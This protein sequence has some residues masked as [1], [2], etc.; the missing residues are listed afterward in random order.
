MTH[1]AGL[2]VAAVHQ[3]RGLRVG[4]MAAP[5]TLLYTICAVGFNSVGILSTASILLSQVLPLLG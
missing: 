1:P 3:A 2:P 4:R 5:G